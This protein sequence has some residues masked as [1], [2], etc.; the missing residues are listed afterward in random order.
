MKVNI[1]TQSEGFL[2]GP[3]VQFLILAALI[4]IFARK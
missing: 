4:L 3:N 2:G 1:D